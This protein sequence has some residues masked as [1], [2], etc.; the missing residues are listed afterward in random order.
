MHELT[1]AESV[2]EQITG[3]MGDTPISVVCLEIGELSGVVPDAIR[4]CFDM[5][6]EGTPVAGAH[7]DIIEV[8]GRCA[9]HA[10]GRVFRP[11]DKL[12]LCV[13]G[14]ADVGIIAGE[15]LRIASVGVNEHV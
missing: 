6:A 4:F 2:I 3:R 8:L 13:C 5:A 12:L 10:C 14:S 7:L 11:A 9:C 1:I 15:D